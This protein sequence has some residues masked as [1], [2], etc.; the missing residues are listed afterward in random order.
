MIYDFKCETCGL[1]FEA[2]TRMND[3]APPCPKCKDETHRLISPPSTF[4]IREH[5]TATDDGLA[6]RVE[7]YKD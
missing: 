3:P 5:W 6:V 4:Y 2:R 7:D 1:E